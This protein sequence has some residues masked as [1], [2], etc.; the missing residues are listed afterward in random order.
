MS[1][2]VERIKREGLS[3]RLTFVIML[4]ISLGMTVCLLVA[5]FLSFRSFRAL[6][7]ATDT[8]IEL[9]NTAQALLNASDYLTE[10]AQCYTVLVDRVHLDRYMDEA[11]VKK[12]REKAVEAMQ[13]KLPESDALDELKKA[14]QDSVALMDREYY[15]MLLVLTAK[16]DDDIPEPMRE[17]TL[18]D[19]DLALSRGGKLALARTMMHDS[20]YYDQKNMVRRD[21]ENCLENLR[22]GTH[23][24]QN[25][26]ER[27]MK[28]D[29]TWLMILVILQSLFLILLLWLTTSLGI[30]PLLTAVEHIKK[31]Q[32]IPIVGANEFR[33]LAGT[34]NKMYSAY[35]KSIDNLS[36]KA[37]H[38]ELTGTY[39]RSGFDLIKG[40]VDLSTTA[41]LLFDADKFK[42]V[43]DSF[44]HEVGDKVLKKIARILVEHFRADD[45]V[46]R[47]GGDEFIVLMVHVKQEVRHLIEHKVVQINRD[48]SDISDNVPP[49][50]LSAGV[51]LCED[52]L[53]ADQMLHRSD[54]ALYYV[55]DHGRNDCCFYRQ[56][57][58]HVSKVV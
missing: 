35:K 34:Y 58:E 44:G 3:L 45:Y 17:V 6:S 46:C 25:G 39:N 53:N 7:D 49:I 36:F 33:Y 9:Q 18:S 23:A 56:D 31:D 22:V 28:T 38:D 27:Q 51:C 42:S 21:L 43:N 11:L 40:S 55:K 15:A 1:G 30:N 5:S 2:W 4:I 8:Y 14:M 19:K 24:A 52:G 10:E 29:L 32:R 12:R 54:I 16:G 57:M 47:I 13:E 48:L 41:F 20:K 37:S 50:T 26:S